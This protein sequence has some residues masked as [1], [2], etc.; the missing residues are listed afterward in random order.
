MEGWGYT[1]AILPNAQLPDNPDTQTIP[2]T[3]AP[4]LLKPSLCLPLS[5]TVGLLENLWGK[6]GRKEK[7]VKSKIYLDEES[8]ADLAY[9]TP[10]P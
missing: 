7:V 1:R 9:I 4:T 3:P 2:P 8:Q 5:K 10:N 6:S